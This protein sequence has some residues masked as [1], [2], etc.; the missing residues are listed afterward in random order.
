MSGNCATT[1]RI[2]STRTCWRP[3]TSSRSATTAW[4]A[5]AAPSAAGTFSKPDTRSSTRSSTGNGLRHGAPLRTSRTPTP[6]GPPHLCADPAAAAQP[7]GRGSRPIEAQ[8]SMK[9]GMPWGRASSPT[10]WIVPTSW[11]A[12][13]SATTLGVPRAASSTRPV[14]D[15]AR[16][17]A[18]TSVRQARAC[19]TAECSTAE[20]ATVAPGGTSPSNPR[21]TASV[22]DPVNETSSRRTPSA[23]ATAS[24]ALSRIRRALRAGLCSRRGSAY[25]WSSA[26]SSASRAAGCSGSD[27]AASRYPPVT[28]VENYPSRRPSL[29]GPRSA[30][31]SRRLNDDLACGAGVRRPRNHPSGRPTRRV[32]GGTV[33]LGSAVSEQ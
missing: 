22:P 32:V 5:A 26:A 23:S 13:W 33:G 31:T 3:L 4:S 27:D 7:A 16:L 14:E 8:A 17:S 1:D 24:R 18:C 28:T 15:T 30:R 19:N 25:P 10:G 6:A 12:C 2:R 9:S 29:G 21:C 11:L 20:W